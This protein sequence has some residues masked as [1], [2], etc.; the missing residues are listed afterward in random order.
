MMM[1]EKELFL[2]PLEAQDQEAWPLDE[3]L[4]RDVGNIKEF[5]VA[6]ASKK[7]VGE[8]RGLVGEMV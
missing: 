1:S 4:L 2:V 8:F 3:K 6:R 5:S 7:A